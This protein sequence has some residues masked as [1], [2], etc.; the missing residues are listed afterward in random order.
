[1]TRTGVF[2]C[3]CDQKIAKSIQVDA[4][5]YV[6]RSNREVVVVSPQEHLCLPDGLAALRE[7]I[8]R[9]KLDQVVVAAC[10]TRFQEKH[11]RAACVSAGINENAF[12]LVDWRE[13]CAYVHRGDKV[14]ATGKAIDL[15][16]MT[17]A[18]VT[19]AAPADQV[20]VEIEPRVLVIGGGIAGLTA[21]RAIAEHSIAVTLVEQDAELGGHARH[22]PLNGKAH[23]FE[24]TRADVLNHPRIDVRLSTRV[25]SVTGSVGAYRV[26]LA[27]CHGANRASSNGSNGAAHSTEVVAGAVVIAIGAQEYRDAHLYH[28]D[29]RRVVTLGEFEI[30]N[31]KFKIQNSKLEIQKPVPNQ[32]EGAKIENGEFPTSV[33]YILC[34]GSRNAHIPYCSNVCCLGALDQALRVKRAHPEAQVT[35]L[36]RDLYL[37]GDELNEEIV[38]DAR[39]LGIEFLRYAEAQPPHVNGETVTVHDTRTNSMQQLH[40]D[41]LVLATPRVPRAEAGVLARLFKLPRDQFGFLIDPHWRV[42]PEQQHPRGIFVCG[43]AHQPVDMDTATMQGM[44][45]AAQAAR[46]IHKRVLTHPAASAVV[47]P[48]FCTG[49]AQCVETCAFGAITLVSRTPRAERVGRA[50][51]ILDR[52]QIDPFLCLACGNCVVACPAK[53]IDLCGGVPAATNLGD[54]QIYAQLDAALDA[55]H[56]GETRVVVFGCHWSGF[57]AMELAGARRL[58]YSADTR[59]IELPCSARL[60]PLHVLYALLHGADEVVLALCPPDECH[61][62]NGNHFAERRIENLRAQLSA[63]GID[64]TRVRHVR[65]MGDDA[66]AWVQAVKA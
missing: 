41:R 26:E 46:F 44:T 51:A 45:A 16:Q 29:G 15:L 43:S 12:A 55:R 50:I 66:H 11:L 5:P 61:Y 52:A 13:G 6:L 31:S 18:R 3:T 57:A 37:L 19:S 28:H 59:V 21:A 49:C 23:A 20:T 14:K 56:E 48:A 40:Y 2:L 33:V 36:F 9:H 25:V 38:L 62:A 17:L 42:R 7:T 47:N 35:I 65:L 60:D 32:H 64:P 24:T 30:Q 27:E 10:P 63:H 8:A 54:A 34:A 58:Q 39:R 22:V 53:A 4:I 1:M